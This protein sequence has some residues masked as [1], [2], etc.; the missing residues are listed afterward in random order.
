MKTK[1]TN[2]SQRQTDALLGAIRGETSKETAKRLKLSPRTVESYREEA[3]RLLQA[4][5]TGHACLLAIKRGLLR[6]CNVVSVNLFSR[7]PSW[8]LSGC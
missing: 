2:L 3:R 5:N 4:K 1:P 8:G 7:V 6:E